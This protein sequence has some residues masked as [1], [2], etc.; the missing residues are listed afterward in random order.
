[1][2]RKGEIC[3]VEAATDWGGE[4]VVL[5]KVDFYQLLLIYMMQQTTRNHIHIPLHIAN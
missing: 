4:D 5:D 2:E 1:M 3:R